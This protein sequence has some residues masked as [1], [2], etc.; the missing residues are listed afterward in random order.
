MPS[1]SAG[2]QKR[3]LTDLLTTYQ[4]GRAAITL[5][6]TEVSLT[7]L[8]GL[9]VGGSAAS[10]FRPGGTDRQQHWTIGTGLTPFDALT[11]AHD[12]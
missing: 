8:D 12:D 10:H 4:D 1:S 6:S 9:K 5:I 2:T 11:I 7:R 3:W